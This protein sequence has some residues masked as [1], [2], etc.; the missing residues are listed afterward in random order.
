MQRLE[1]RESCGR[2]E[3]RMKRARRVKDTSRRPTE[4]TNLGRWGL[5]ETEPPTKEPARGST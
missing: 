4:A 1:L 2:V 5:T 3:G